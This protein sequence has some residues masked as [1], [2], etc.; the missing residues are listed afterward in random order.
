MPARFVCSW[1][2]KIAFIIRWVSFVC[3]LA[4]NSFLRIAFVW[5]GESLTHTFMVV[6]EATMASPALSE[7]G[8][9]KLP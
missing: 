3:L 4:S 7:F 1:R 9:K 2:E 8:K 5:S 6:T